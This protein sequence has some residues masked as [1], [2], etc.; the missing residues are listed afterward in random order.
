MTLSVKITCVCGM[1][2]VSFL[3]SAD[4]PGTWIGTWASSPTAF[5]PQASTLPAPALVHGTVRYRVRI[6]Q[7]GA[8]IRLRFSNEYG[9]GRLNLTAASVGLANGGLDAAAGSLKRV[10]FGGNPSINIPA[11]APALSDPIAFPVK[12]LQDLVVSVYVPDGVAMFACPAGQTPSDQTAVQGL[13]AT[14]NEHLSALECRYTV[15]PLVS[16]IDVQASG[17]RKVVVALGDSITDGGLDPKTGER[18]W[19]GALSRRLQSAAISVVNAGIGGNRLLESLP[20]N[21]ASALARL[22]RDVLSV[23]GI[24]QIIILEGINDIRYGGPDGMYSDSPPVGSQDLISAYCQIIERAHERGIKV[25]GATLLPFEGARYYSAA[26]EGVRT[27]ANEWIRR[28]AR[29]DGIVDFDAAMRDAAAP[30]KLMTEYDSGDH[31]HPSPA[32]YR[33]MADAV[34]LSLLTR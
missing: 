17:R 21:G 22:D 20:M 32:G 9:N 34:D 6:S 8:Q 16:A 5:A 7:G 23:P 13:D 28:S 33:H 10:T 24:S 30:R 19:P 15:R 3:A 18:G 29:F 25:I 27:R 1:L 26:R 2:A 4:T 11:G 31:I 14:G 12:S